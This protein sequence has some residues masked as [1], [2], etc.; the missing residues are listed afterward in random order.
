M[1]QEIINNGSYQGDPSAESIFNSFNKVN[2]NFTENYTDIEELKTDIQSAVSGYQGDLQ[3]ADTPTLD[4]YYYPTESGT[5]TNAGGLVVDLTAGLNIIT[6]IGSEFSLITY[7]LTLVDYVSKSTDIETGVVKDSVKLVESGDIYNEFE[8]NKKA[9]FDGR[10]NNYDFTSTIDY[11]QSTLYPVFG[12]FLTGEKIL[13]DFTSTTNDF[14][15][16]IQAQRASDSVFEIIEQYDSV[17]NIGTLSGEIEATK[18]Y[19][20]VAIF[21]G[22]GATPGTITYSFIGS[23]SLL[24][25]EIEKEKKYGL[26]QIATYSD[27]YVNQGKF[28]NKTTGGLSTNSS[29]EATDFIKVTAGE[30]IS[31]MGFGSDGTAALVVFYDTEQNF[32]SSESGSTINLKVQEYTVAQDGFIRCTRQ[33]GQY[34]FVITKTVYSL[35]DLEINLL[36]RQ[37]N[38]SSFFFKNDNRFVNS[39]GGT[40]P[41]TSSSY[42]DYLEYTGGDIL[43]KGLSGTNACLVVFYDENKDVLGFVNGAENDNKIVLIRNIPV[44]TKYVRASGNKDDDTNLISMM[45]L[46]ELYQLNIRN[47]AE[48]YGR[49]GFGRVADY[50]LSNIPLQPVKVTRDVAGYYALYDGLVSSYPNYVTKIDMDVEAVNIGLS[51]PAQLLGLP[52]YMYEFKPRYMPVGVDHTQ[53]QISNEF[54]IMIL[55]GIHPEYTCVETL[56]NFMNQL[57]SNW[58]NNKNLEDLRFNATFYII[59]VGSPYSIENNQ[60]VNYNGVDLNRNNNTE[61]WVLTADNGSTYSGPEPNSEYETKI[62]DHYF[63]NVIKPDLFIDFHNFQ[64]DYIGN[65][66]YGTSHQQNVID[67]LSSA[68]SQNTRLWKSDN[69]DYPNDAETPLGWIDYTPE[70][71]TRGVYGSENGA[72]SCTYESCNGSA[73]NAGTLEVTQQRTMDAQLMKESLQGFGNVL[74]AMCKEV[75]LKTGKNTYV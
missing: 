37:Y 64:V 46:S 24:N 41:N 22:S 62:F 34:G 14:A 48:I 2:L 16:Q 70:T 55:S 61:D 63:R 53:P 42:T 49:Y 30:D 10:N 13:Y 15:I 38:N 35:K 21:I 9:V 66:C 3:I 8:L 69:S 20:Q 45:S 27:L 75:V 40:T 23:N 28:V 57:C 6:K 32:V 1:A 60:R 58:Q 7:P 31:V 39:T 52:S 59:P 4:G 72:L 74:L 29:Y 43:V 73:W 12:K 68:I 25:V 47:N 5:Y 33:I 65:M 18:D 19:L 54:K 67:L 44:G 51:V 36:T 50:D 11:T 26:T 56:Y 17:A 71:G